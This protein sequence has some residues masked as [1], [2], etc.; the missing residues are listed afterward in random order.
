MFKIVLSIL[1]LI[2]NAATLLPVRV[3][4]VEQTIRINEIM[5][6]VK[7]MSDADH[8]WVE[9]YNTSSTAVSLQGFKFN[10]G[11]NHTL[12]APPANG[13][14]GKL[15][16]GPNE[17]AIIT[18][19]AATYLSDHPGYTGTVIDT[20]MSLNNA[21]AT[22]SLVNQ[23]GAV[24]DTFTY[25]S[26]LG[27]NGDGQ[28]LSRLGAS[29]QSTNP[30]P[31]LA[32]VVSDTPPDQSPV[33][34]TEN[35]P[36]TE[37]NNEVQGSL[38]Q[39]E[40]KTSENKI[41]TVPMKLVVTI[42]AKVSANVPFTLQAQAFGTSGEL[43][44]GGQYVWSMGDGMSVV[45]DSSA[46][47]VYTYMS[48]GEYVVYLEYY[49]YQDQTTPELR[50]RKNITA[51]SSVVSASVDFQNG[52]FT[53]TNTGGYE[54]D[55]KG[56]IISVNKVDFIL[57]NH[58]IIPP[59]IAVKIPFWI[60]PTPLTKSDVIELINPSE[61]R[62]VISQPASAVSSPISLVSQQTLT[63]KK[64]V[65]LKTEATATSQ[66]STQEFSSKPVKSKQSVPISLVLIG[67][68]VISVCASLSVL[69]I[70]NKKSDA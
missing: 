1:I 67:F 18:G 52:V 69:Y 11:S 60:I 43:L 61:Q 34:D 20:V 6:D 13:G 70:Q 36:S 56:W 17:Y 23:S 24:I 57:R 45:R 12:N 47:F 31:G 10:D 2:L 50:L 40:S 29:I 16:I 22:L 5:Y 48:S 25:T 39:Q 4:A 8:E 27:G 42:P 44:I 66:K 30:T 54:V 68:V 58:T 64:D 49:R 63:Q 55:L 35:T 51:Y 21:G 14:Q 3:F 19:N 38:G 26:A 53:V 7:D 46:E 65:V 28:T 37:Q 59:K 62:S 9:L 33:N 41:K 32:N 15:E